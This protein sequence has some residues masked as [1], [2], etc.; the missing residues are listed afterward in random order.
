MRENG[1]V[2][3]RVSMIPCFK[4]RRYV[5]NFSSCR[6]INWKLGQ[7]G[8]GFRNCRNR[9]VFDLL[10]LGYTTTNSL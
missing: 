2:N 6:P 4:S 5:R 7:T 9:N 8:M 1:P 3:G 10:R